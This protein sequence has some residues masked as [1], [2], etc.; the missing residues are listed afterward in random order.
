MDFWKKNTTNEKLRYEVEKAVDPLIKNLK[1]EFTGQLDKEKSKLLREVRADIKAEI[2]SG[3][4]GVLGSKV[5]FFGGGLGGIVG[6]LGSLWSL[7]E[8]FSQK[9]KPGLSGVDAILE[10]VDGLKLD[11]EALQSDVLERAAFRAT[12]PMA[13][14]LAESTSREEIPA[15]APTS[16]R[17]RKT[18]RTLAAALDNEWI[19]SSKL[20]ETAGIRKGTGHTHG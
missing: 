16:T 17:R 10:V 6:G 3:V 18:I 19:I 9:Y 1:K 2:M 13:S 20:N 4:E 12:A 8:K 14:Y 7:Y 11:V 15:P 5:S